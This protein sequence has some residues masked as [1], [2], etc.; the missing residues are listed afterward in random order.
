MATSVDFAVEKNE[1]LSFDFEDFHRLLEE[2]AVTDD[3]LK[4]CDEVSILN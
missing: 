3:V 2:E 4:L 1:M